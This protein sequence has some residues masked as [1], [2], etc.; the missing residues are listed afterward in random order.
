[1][2]FFLKPMILLMRSPKSGA[3]AGAGAEE[4][5]WRLTTTTTARR[6]SRTLILPHGNTLEKWRETV[7]IWIT[8]NIIAIYI[9]NLS[10]RKKEGV[11][12]LVMCW[13]EMRMAGKLWR[14]CY[15]A[16]VR[17]AYI[18]GRQYYLP[19]SGENRDHSIVDSGYIYNLHSTHS[20]PGHRWGWWSFTSPD[21]FPP[22]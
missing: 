11:F 20:A 14:Y 12:Y 8:S 15:S 10:E 19:R 5:E 18:P 3:G 13:D 17:S 16:W 1:M 21:D 22:R 7:N 4:A 2:R 6:H 9:V